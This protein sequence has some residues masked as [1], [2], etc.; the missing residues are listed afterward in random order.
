MKTLHRQVAIVHRGRSVIMDKGIAPLILA[1]WRQV[2]K[3]S[4]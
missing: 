4:V 1:L 2:E 3:S